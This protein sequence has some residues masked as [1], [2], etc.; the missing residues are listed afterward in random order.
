MSCRS[1]AVLV[2]LVL[3]GATGRPAPVPP[4]AA[5]RRP[6]TPGEFAAAVK[7]YEAL[8]GSGE[9]FGGGGRDRVYHGFK[10]FK[11]TAEACGKLPD[12]PFEYRLTLFIG[13]DTPAGALAPLGRLDNLRWVEVELRRDD[14]GREPTPAD[15]TARV[16]ELAAV[17]NLERL[18]LWNSDHLLTDELAGKLTEFK[19]LRSLVGRGPITD[20]GLAALAR[21]PKLNHLSFQGCPNATDAGLAHLAAMPNLRWLVLQGYPKATAA[22]LKP[23]AV[24][25]RLTMLAGGPGVNGEALEVV[26]S[27]HTLERLSLDG[28]RKGR[29]TGRQLA[30]LGRL[31]RLRELSVGDTRFDDEAAAGL[32]GAA[33]LEELYIS[34]ASGVT[35]AGMTD[36]AKLANLKTVT[37][38]GANRVTDTGLVHLAGLPRLETLGLHGLAGAT[39]AGVAELA[40]LPKLG[41]LRLVEAGRV[42]DGGLKA[43]AGSKSLTELSVWKSAA[44]EAGAR[45]VVAG[46]G[47]AL[48]TLSVRGLGIGDDF[49]AFVAAT[50]PDLVSIDLHDNPRVTEKSME[51]LFAMSR[52]QSASLHGTGIPH[53]TMLAFWKR[54]RERERE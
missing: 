40:R 14:R 5:H 53:E 25:P 35:D 31:P 41:T 44:T 37:L 21:H 42:G 28:D 51:I 30:A 17:P 16:A 54:L 13:P 2:G 52:L 36:L 23:F 27:I 24:E 9:K 49:V 4:A 34:D 1:A 45:A 12:Q 20:A 47:K 46:R 15:A 50:A 10:L 33:A 3:L 6:P 8:G 32:A 43:L 19:A 48:R 7:A 22:G 38:L 11:P 39:D 18:S 26:A 29:T